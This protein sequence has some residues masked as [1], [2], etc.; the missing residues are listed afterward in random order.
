MSEMVKKTKKKCNQTG[1][2]R[3]LEV[4]IL[5]NVILKT[6]KCVKGYDGQS[7]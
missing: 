5:L 6:Q 7:G 2:M 1:K 4:I 3:L